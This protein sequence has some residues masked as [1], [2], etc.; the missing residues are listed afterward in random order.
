ML[1]AIDWRPYVSL[2]LFVVSAVIFAVVIA[3]VLRKGG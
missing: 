2:G 3:L 1:L